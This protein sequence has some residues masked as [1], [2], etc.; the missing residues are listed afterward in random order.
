MVHQDGADPGYSGM[1]RLGV[2]HPPERDPSQSKGLP[3]NIKF[4]THLYTWVVRGTV[5]EKCLAQ[6]HR[7]MSP[8]R[9]RTRDRSILRRSH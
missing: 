6:E 8:P 7:T 2:L 1:K 3:P 9:A 5:T 4:G